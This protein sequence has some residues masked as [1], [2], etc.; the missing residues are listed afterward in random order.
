[1]TLPSEELLVRFAPLV[2]VETCPQILAHQATD[3]FRFWDALEEEQGEQ[4]EVP[5]WGAV[6]PAA[7]SLARFILTN[8]YLVKDKNVLDLGCGSGVSS[9]AA[10]MAGAKKVTA[11]DI[12]QTALFIAQKGFLANKVSVNADSRNFLQEQESETFDLIFVVDMFYERSNSEALLSFIQKHRKLGADVIIADGTRPF[13]PK[14]NVELLH[15]EWIDVDRELE[16]ISQREVHLF[17][18]L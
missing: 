5:F 11:N 10:S 3:F 2:P 4:T 15:N 1:M 9:I 13:T 17:R 18:L 16:G 12:D 8:E 6:W 14:E 7:K